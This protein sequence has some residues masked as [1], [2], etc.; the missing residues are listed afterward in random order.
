MT[1]TEEYLDTVRLYEQEIA[2]IPMLSAEE[3]RALGRR[4]QKGDEEAADRLALA[5]LRLADF[6]ARKAAAHCDVPLSDLIQ[7]GNIGV[8]NA[9]RRFDPSKGAFAAYAKNHVRYE[10]QL[11]IAKSKGISDREYR[12]IETIQQIRRLFVQESGS[13]PTYQEIAERL[14]SKPETVADLMLKSKGMLSL[15]EQN[16][17]ETVQQDGSDSRY[18]DPA[19]LLVAAESE[20]AHRRGLRMLGEREAY[21][22]RSRLLY[23]DVKEKKTL[24]EL[25]QELHISKERVRQIER[26]ALE[27][28]LRFYLDQQ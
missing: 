28:L 8:L 5:N 26:G 17:D 13:E 12:K 6:Y 24:E 4:I 2:R 27:K 15:E 10:I 14:H 18:A 20:A 22:I 23:A 9:A 7:A 16:E 25:S 11:A 21:I 1:E 19:D 3:E